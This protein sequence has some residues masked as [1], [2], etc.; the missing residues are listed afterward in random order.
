LTYDQ[1][2]KMIQQAIETN[3][4]AQERFINGTDIAYNKNKHTIAVLKDLN[5]E[6]WLLHKDGMKTGELIAI[7]NCYGILGVKIEDLEKSNKELI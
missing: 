6:I 5:K 7:E 2:E 1:E 3:A 4:G